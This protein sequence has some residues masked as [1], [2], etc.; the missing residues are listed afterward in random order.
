M[1]IVVRQAIPGVLGRLAV[2]AGQARRQQLQMDR[3]IQFTQIALA[4]QD[5]AAAI[6]AAA[7]DRAFAMQRAA[8]TQ[9][10]RQRPAVPDARQQRQRLRQFVSEAKAADIY[11]PAQIK[12]MQIFADLGDEGAVRSIA[13]RLPPVSARRR[14]LEEQAQTVAEIG[15][16]DV[17]AIQQQ[18]AAVNEQLGQKFEP[19][20]QRY[21]REN[22]EFMARFTSP[23][24]QELMAQQQQ[25][26]EQIAAVRERTIR[27]GRMLQLG[28][29]VPEQRAFEMKQRAELERQEAARQR[30]LAQQVGRVGGLTER[31]ELAVDVIRDR[32]RDKRTAIGREIT[33]LSKGL[34][35]FEDESESDQLKRIGPIRT[36]IRMLELRQTASHANEKMQI[37]TFLRR[38]EKTTG[39]PE[40]FIRGTIYTNTAG[41]RARFMGYDETG[42]PLMDLVE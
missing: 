5:R 15:K 25:L 40:K 28:I 41:Q 8:A 26:E 31:E 11:D 32:E 4:A 12:Q 7:R 18:L 23:K 24:I 34:A 27:T 39:R 42:Q 37:E 1:P 2:R 9:I 14:E 33:R 22:P 6:G 13:G 38:D 21:L 10:A 16:R 35:P 36:E 17:S 29:T 30:R 19:P 3:D 20:M